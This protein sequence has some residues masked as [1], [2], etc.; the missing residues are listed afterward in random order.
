MWNHVTV[1][2][3]GGKYSSACIFDIPNTFWVIS[4]YI[5]ELIISAHHCLCQSTSHFLFLPLVPPRLLV[6]YS[7]WHCCVTSATDSW[8]LRCQVWLP[9]LWYQCPKYR[10]S[11]WEAWIAVITTV[12]RLFLGTTA[13]KVPEIFDLW[14]LCSCWSSGC[15]ALLPMRVLSTVVVSGAFR[16]EH[17]QVLKP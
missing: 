17:W 1:I 4:S 7:C 13:T 14:Y 3:C 11:W 9:L 16:F 12:R 8:N 5:W 6:Y 15:Q 2:L 10:P